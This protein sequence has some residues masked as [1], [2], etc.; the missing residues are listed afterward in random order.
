[1]FLLK[2]RQKLESSSNKANKYANIAQ[3]NNLCADNFSSRNDL[4]I[5]FCAFKDLIIELLD[6]IKAIIL[7]LLDYIYY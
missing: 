3:A 5:Y 7:F 6:N 1:M 4:I 2:Y